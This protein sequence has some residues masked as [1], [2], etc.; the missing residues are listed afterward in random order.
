MIIKNT[1]GSVNFKINTKGMDD[2]LHKAQVYL[3]NRVLT[4]SNSF[5]AKKVGNLRQSGI[6][7]TR[8][9]SGIVCW[10]TIYAHYQ[11][12]GRVMVG[13]QSRRAWAMRGEPKEYNGNHL[14]YSQPGARERW[15]E[16]AKKKYLKSWLNGVKKIFGR[17]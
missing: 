17:K 8:L 11:Y 7:H 5:A 1:V 9:G 16:V 6:E 2:K 4:D 15:F 3:D 12:E 14:S 10:S 13:K